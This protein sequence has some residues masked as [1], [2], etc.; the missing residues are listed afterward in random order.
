MA[1][2][3]K[4]VHILCI[5]HIK[6]WKKPKKR[7]NLC[8]NRPKKCMERCITLVAAVNSHPQT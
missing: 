1:D 6:W 7:L 5:S 3:G 8:I 4:Y 2:S